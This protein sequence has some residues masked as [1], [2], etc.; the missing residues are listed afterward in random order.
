MVRDPVCG[1]SLEIG[2][3]LR[4]VYHDKAYYFCSHDCKVNFE[5]RPDEYVQPAHHMLGTI[6]TYPLEVL[7][8]AIQ[9]A[10]AEH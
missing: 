6:V 10:E 8:K 1:I 7:A 5:D 2:H 3:A 4:V 9:S